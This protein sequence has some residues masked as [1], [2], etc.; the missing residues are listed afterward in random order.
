MITAL[1]SGRKNSK[2]IANKNV[3]PLLG[4]PLMWYSMQAALHA[5]QVDRLYVSTDSDEIADLG[6]SH[7]GRVIDRPA[8]LATDEALLEDV[9]QHGYQAI[10]ADL[11]APPEM[12]VVILC[13]AA[14]IQSETID[15]AI[16]MLRADPG[17]DSVATVRLLNQYSPV[18]A[19]RIENGRMVP[20]VDP[21]VF[22][23]AITCD[24]KCTGDIYFCDAS[25]WV[26]RPRC[27]DYS[28]GQPP[29]LWMGSAILPLVQ[30][31]GLDVDDAEGLW[32][33]E[34]WLRARG[35]SETATP[36]DRSR[37]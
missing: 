7:G 22:G 4:R 24:R 31:G 3:T 16:A 17:A 1:L 20:A 34:A 32:Q 29:F 18:R 5:A 23:G 30:E 14:T 11:G 33:T 25:L 9:L 15:R 6:R 13:N 27:M 36:Y 2:G 21:A 10:A 35:F 19:K 8:A 37:P 28:K 26:L 12:L